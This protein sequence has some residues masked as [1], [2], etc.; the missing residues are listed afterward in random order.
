MSSQ[1]HGG[2]CQHHP[3]QATPS[4]PKVPSFLQANLSSQVWKL[5]L[6]VPG[7]LYMAEKQVRWS[8]VVVLATRGDCT[9]FP[10]NCIYFFVT[11]HNFF[12]P[13]FCANNYYT[14][15][16]LIVCALRWYVKSLYRH[17]FLE[18]IAKQARREKNGTSPLPSALI[19]RRLERQTPNFLLWLAN[20]LSCDMAETIITT[21]EVL[22]RYETLY[23]Q[24]RQK[25]RNIC[26]PASSNHHNS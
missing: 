20:T 10:E 4:T 12:F 1:G 24:P 17:F 15:L 21:R 11:S 13:F 8:S 19:S 18:D 22:N 6:V 5:S 9:I 25:P 3:I 16:L 7:S 26:D 2:Q 14:S 23:F